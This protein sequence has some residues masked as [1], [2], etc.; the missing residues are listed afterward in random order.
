MKH[1]EAIHVD[2][3]TKNATCHIVELLMFL[4]GV[5]RGM[6]G[7]SS[8]NV[9]LLFVMVLWVNITAMLCKRAVLMLWHAFLF[10][11]LRFSLFFLFA[12][13]LMLLF[14][15]TKISLKK[16]AANSSSHESAKVGRHTGSERYID[17]SYM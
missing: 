5:F 6:C 4:F 8:C 16:I 10:L 13:W 11:G 15:C 1:V 17:L 9:F 3:H 2:A 7:E 14:S 12:W